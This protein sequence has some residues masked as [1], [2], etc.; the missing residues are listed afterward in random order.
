MGDW[1]RILCAVDV[2]D[3]AR[4][5]VDAAASLARKL[6]AQLT[7]LYVV[8]TGEPTTL[9][10]FPERV[11]AMMT[12]A[13]F[14]LRQLAARAGET[15]GAPVEPRVHHGNPESV[16]V[17]KARETGCDMLVLGTH[18]R[19]GLDRALFGSIAEKV[20]RSAPCPVLIVRTP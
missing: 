5:V 17:N 19:R 16:I 14:P 15:A 6:G 12:E 13:T 2:H 20:L 10:A 8:P 3:D 7:L 1:S 18:A 11:E 9:L 4:P